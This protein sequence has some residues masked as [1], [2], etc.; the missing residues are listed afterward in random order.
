MSSV[1]EDDTPSNVVTCR[2]CETSPPLAG[3]AYWVCL[4]CC[5]QEVCH[6]CF[7]GM[8]TCP[9]CRYTPMTAPQVLDVYWEM[10]L[11]GTRGVYVMCSSPD[12]Q[13]TFLQGL[14]AKARQCGLTEQTRST[15]RWQVDLLCPNTR[16]WPN[17]TLTFI[18]GNREATP[19]SCFNAAYTLG[20]GIDR[21]ETDK[22]AAECAKRGQHG[23][24][25]LSFTLEHVMAWLG[26]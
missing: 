6:S 16:P 9:L 20:V 10:W 2:M 12:V 15:N 4:P 13:E 3:D 25:P 19:L 17:E 8:S 1:V 18:S 14:R 21:D 5:K 24:V 26:Q 22:K 7:M 11:R 23:C